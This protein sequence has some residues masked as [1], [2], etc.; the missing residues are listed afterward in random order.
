M[1]PEPVP[2]V[3]VGA[4]AVT[5]QPVNVMIVAQVVFPPLSFSI[6]AAIKNC[7]ALV[8]NATPEPYAYIAFG[9]H[10]LFLPAVGSIGTPFGK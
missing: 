6:S 2:F 3:R 8:S 7:G 9:Q 5:F 10:A 4:A 1:Y